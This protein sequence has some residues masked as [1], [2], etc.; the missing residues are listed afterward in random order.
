RLGRGGMAE[1]YKAFHPGLN[2]YRAIKIIRPELA[3]EPQFQAR[4]QRE[5]QAAAAMRH[6]NIVHVHD[7]GVADGHYYMVMEYL[8][9]TDLRQILQ[10]EG[11]IRPFSRILDVLKPIVLA[12]QYA[13][14]HGVIHR[15]LKPANIMLTTTGDVV[16]TDFGIAKR[17]TLETAEEL[18]QT[19]SVL[20]TPAYMAPEQMRSG[21]SS[22]RT[23][24]YSLGVI[25]FE[26]MTGRVP[27][28]AE[29]PVGVIAKVISEE[30][31]HPSAIRPDITPPLENV[32]LKATAKAP[33][34]RYPTPTD[35]SYALTAGLEET[36]KGLNTIVYD[37]ETEMMEAET[38]V[39]HQSTQR[40]GSRIGFYPIGGL[41]I[42][43][44]AVGGWFMFGGGGSG[45]MV[46]EPTAAPVALVVEETPT[47][48]PTPTEQATFTPTPTAEPTNTLLP[49]PT[50]TATAPPTATP[51]APQFP[52]T[53]LTG[54]G[55][56]VAVLGR[57]IDWRHPDFINPDGTTRIKH[58]LDMSSQSG[59]CQAD[60]AA[61]IEY[62]AE[63][64]NA[65]LINGE[66]LAHRDA[67]GHGT[68]TAGFA[69]GNGLAL[70]SR[71][72]AGLAT[73]ADLIV[74]KI[75]SE[76]AEA[77]G[78]FPA[79]PRFNACFDEALDWLDGKL[80]ALNQPA[81]AV[82]NVGTQW[83]PMDGTSATSRKIN[84]YFGPDRPGRVWVAA[85]GVEERLDN[86][87]GGPFSA[88]E[89]VVLPFN[90]IADGPGIMT[91]WYSGGLPA[92]LYIDLPDGKEVGPVGPNDSIRN[93]KGVSIYHYEPGQSFYPWQSTGGDRAI[94]I[95]LDGYLGQGTLRLEPLFAGEGHFD[96]YGNFRGPN[97]TSSIV[98]LDQLAEGRL[99]NQA[100]TYNIITVASYTGAAQYEDSEGNM[101]PVG[102]NAT[103]GDLWISSASGPT[104]DGRLGVDVAAPGNILV[105][106][107]A[108]N[109]SYSASL[110][111]GIP[112]GE[113]YYFVYR[114][115]GSA[116]GL[117]AGTV[118]LMLEADPTL[119]VTE[120]EA[121]LRETAIV[122]EFTG[123]VPNTRW[124][125]G[126]LNIEAAVA[127]ALSK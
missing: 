125:Y 4:F 53:G 7:F 120:V 32:V 21:E 98:F 89:P 46:A 85:T 69:A 23:D 109:S 24:I 126:K 49:T 87:A 6:P 84:Q 80:T 76:G 45:T 33:K 50:Y 103:P 13:H 11:A 124:G 110:G 100:T 71:R 122:D 58:I 15:D 107:L 111:F 101:R 121:I 117:T 36:Q 90:K 70:S 31:P 2:L 3:S 18:T 60:R 115:S 42:A 5:A 67:V 66:E 41:F 93:E 91:L 62:T 108:Q 77:Q 57:G 20:G 19:G 118:A 95:E 63:Q 22:T 8:E 59:W 123:E 25:L 43:L 72:Y 51:I 74:I 48:E 104:R 61:P 79:E 14:D 16:L 88:E 38:A 83:G 44:L 114:G 99:T 56:T 17:V 102:E 68:A 30:V 106:P 52:Q 96:A 97:R 39:P 75:N 92:A 113:G 29:T 35:L 86:H 28:E 1:V 127:A 73:E 10:S 65:A 40:S 54:R 55:V 64:I 12:L 94:W 105:A 9:G 78:E 47:D 82:W 119:N 26:L 34:E 81:V 37:M 112:S 116:A 27:F